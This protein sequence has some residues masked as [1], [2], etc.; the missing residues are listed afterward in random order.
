VSSTIPSRQEPQQYQ[1]RLHL[2]TRIMQ[3][4]TS[5]L[6]TTRPSSAVVGVRDACWHSVMTPVPNTDRDLA[7]SLA[8][9]HRL[10]SDAHNVVEALQ[11]DEDHANSTI[12]ATTM[13]DLQPNE[14]GFIPYNTMV[15]ATPTGTALFD[16]DQIVGM[17]RMTDTSGT[18]ATVRV[19][20]MEASIANAK[21][22]LREALNRSI[23][24]SNKNWAEYQNLN[25]YV[26]MRQKILT[27]EFLR[28]QTKP[29][30]LYH[31]TDPV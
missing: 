15:S 31:P 11:L 3:Q 7:K 9:F 24:A 6:S 30:L 4:P 10:F 25:V 20:T 14:D 13:T 5:T 26:G 2:S 12:T 21:S 29:L 23:L 22:T 16:P 28:E 17:F 8:I 1:G 18:V 27:D 19:D